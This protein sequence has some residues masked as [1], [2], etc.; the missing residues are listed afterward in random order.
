[1]VRM[2]RRRLLGPGRRPLKDARAEA[3]LFRTRALIAFV[4]VLLALSTLG[5]RFAWL[6]ISKHEEY[7]T[8]ADSNR[9]RIQPIMPTRGLI[10]DRQGRLLADNVPEYR[11][12][13][14]PEQIEDLQAVLARLQRVLPLS[15]EELQRFH[16]AYRSKRRFQSVPLKFRLSEAEVARFAVNRQ[17]FA[18]VEVVPYLSRRYPYAELFGHVVGY[19]GRIDVEDQRRIDPAR[20]AGTT[21]IGKKGIER[22]YEDRLHGKAGFERIEVNAEGRALRVLARTP[23]ESGEHLYLSIDAELQRTAV[24]AFNGQHGAAVAIDPRSGEV[25]AMVSLPGF[26]PNMFVNGISHADYAALSTPS[27]PLFDRT[28]QGGYE[29]GSTIK[30]FVALAG[31]ELGIR[32]PQD[33]TFSSGAFRLPG[34]ARE[35]RDWRRGGHGHVNLREAMAQSVNTYFFQLAHDIG[36]ERFSREMQRFGFGRQTGIDLPGEGIGVLP[37]REWKRSARNE[38]WYPG[39]TVI[40]GIG[41]GF[42]VVTPIQL[43]QATA[44]LAARGRAPAPRLLRATQSAF[45]GEVIEVPPLPPPEHWQMSAANVEAVVDSM[46]AAIHSPTGTGRQAAVGISY[47]MAGKTGTA[48]R[49]TRVGDESLDIDQLPLHL[50]HRALFVAFAPAEAAEIAVM[51]VVESGGSGSLAAAPVARRI[52]DA[53]LVGGGQ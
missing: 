27:R 46:V 34:Q 13:L 14:V 24:A 38:P 31:L 40:S 28:L 37:S 2:V 23:V 35:Y 12:E 44:T 1:M 48:Q 41:Q 19:V 39:E 7:L 20:Y 21:H 15:G 33:T 5:G 4:A 3:A 8:R 36:I 42:W 16:E 45:D 50:R 9:V 32:R 6:Q 52:I 22:F 29:P 25:L 10:Y 43:A 47:R 49:V 53:W 11:L 26:D 30:P 17:Q 18:G 51:V